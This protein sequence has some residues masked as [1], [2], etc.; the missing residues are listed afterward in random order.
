MTICVM[1]ILVLGVSLLGGI[2]LIQ[3]QVRNPL[4]RLSGEL[5]DCAYSSTRIE[6]QFGTAVCT[7]DDPAN[8][9]RFRYGEAPSAVEVLDELRVVR[10]ED[11]AVTLQS[12]RDSISIGPYGISVG[13]WMGARS[14]LAT[15]TFNVDAR[16]C[17]RPTTQAE[18]NGTGQPA[19]RP[20]SK[21]EGSDKPQP[22]AEGHPR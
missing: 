19:P 7:I 12:L 21:S 22:E 8:Q 13:G 9:I 10:F 15:S 4:S 16:G 1:G 20:E 18:Q 6:L 17:L 3:Q 14:P 2:A 11:T 5:N